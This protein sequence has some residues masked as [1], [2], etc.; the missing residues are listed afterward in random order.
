MRCLE[1]VD[2]IVLAKDEI[3][4]KKKYFLI[5]EKRGKY[6]KLTEEQYENPDSCVS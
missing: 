3:F 1:L 2:D 6:L 5:S 4:G